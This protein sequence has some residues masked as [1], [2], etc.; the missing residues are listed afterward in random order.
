[1]QRLQLFN[2]VHQE[3]ISF[4]GYRKFVNVLMLVIF[5]SG[6]SKAGTVY[7]LPMDFVIENPLDKTDFPIVSTN[8]S[9]ST[10][11]YDES[12]FPGVVRAIK[13]LQN[14]I[15]S[16]TGKRPMLVTKIGRAHV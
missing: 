8:G 13:D 16:V 12:D 6:F 14:D 10:I 9:A 1:M 15:D 7:P 2:I 5:F 11:S 4:T 3:P